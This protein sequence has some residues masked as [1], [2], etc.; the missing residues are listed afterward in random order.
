MNYEIVDL[1]EK[2]LASLKPIRISNKNPEVSA[3]ISKLWEEFMKKSHEIEN[4][5]TKKAICTYSNYESDEKGFYDVA[6]GLEVAKPSIKSSNFSLKTIPAGK[7]AKFIV[8][9]PVQ[10]AVTEFWKNLWEM[11]LPRKFDCD[12]EEYQIADP[13]N[14]EVHVFISLK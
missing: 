7:Y 9:D 11:N 3:R 2:T 6:I 5:K 12:F 10:K 4:S 14:T 13:L 1:K 8:K